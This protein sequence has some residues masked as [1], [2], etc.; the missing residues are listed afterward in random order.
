MC[1]WIC[2]YP[3]PLP[4]LNAYTVEKYEKALE[5][6]LG[7]EGYAVWLQYREIQRYKRDREALMVE[8][9]D[10]KKEAGGGEVQKGAHWVM[11]DGGKGNTLHSC[12]I[13][14]TC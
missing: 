6:S 13:L 1:S 5:D 10:S 11:V 7:D 3:P 8:E 9:G 2:P 12:E 4:R 14:G